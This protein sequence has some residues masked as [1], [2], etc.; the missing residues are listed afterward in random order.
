MGM[1]FTQKFDKLGTLKFER[2]GMFGRGD[3]VKVYQN[4]KDVD[5]FYLSDWVLDTL[6]DKNIPESM[7]FSNFKSDCYNWISEYGVTLAED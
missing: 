7:K 5:E 3:K 6:K 2:S 4:G 1:T